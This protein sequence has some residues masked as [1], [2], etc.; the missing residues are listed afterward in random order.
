MELSPFT[1]PLTFT[2]LLDVAVD[3]VGVDAGLS[4]DELRQLAGS[5]DGFDPDTIQNYSLP[6]EGFR[7]SG[8]ASVLDLVEGPETDAILNIFRGLEPGEVLPSQVSV[9]VRNGSG[10]DRQGANTADALSAVGF[11]AAVQGDAEPTA[12]TTVSYAPGSEA[13]ARLVARHLTSKA[14]FEVDEELEANHV[15]LVTGADFSTVVRQPWSEDAVAGPTTTTTTTTTPDP[16]AS[17]STTAPSTTTTEPPTTTTT[18]VGFLPEAPPD[19]E[20]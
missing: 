4:N 17:T 3:S 15:R 19:E 9:E 8:G 7:T 20:C 10:A 12:A 18:H 11:D 5:F 13:A 14:V 16:S 1:N 2:N 6:V